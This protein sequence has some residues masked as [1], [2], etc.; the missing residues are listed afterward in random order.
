MSGLYDPEQHVLDTNSVDCT[1]KMACSSKQ[2]AGAV[3]LGGS[4]LKRAG[5]EEPMSKHVRSSSHILH[6][7]DFLNERR[8]IAFVYLFMSWKLINRSFYD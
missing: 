2:G 3:S 1:Q 8:Y 4:L 6:K 5:A 7:R